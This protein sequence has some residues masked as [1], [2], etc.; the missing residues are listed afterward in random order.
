MRYIYH[1]YCIE[2]RKGDFFMIGRFY[3]LYYE[4]PFHM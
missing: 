4:T 1:V 2:V 3:R